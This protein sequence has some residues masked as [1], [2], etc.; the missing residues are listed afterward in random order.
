MIKINFIFFKFISISLKK[1]IN[2]PTVSSQAPKMTVQKN[3]SPNRG[4]YLL[5]LF[6]F[7]HPLKDKNTPHLLHP[8][9]MLEKLCYACFVAVFEGYGCK[10]L[11]NFKNCLFSELNSNKTIVFIDWELNEGVKCKSISETLFQN[12]EFFLTL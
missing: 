7:P 2:L 5:H 6:G 1:L 4:I 8:H 3:R 10:M 9:P 12:S 11:N